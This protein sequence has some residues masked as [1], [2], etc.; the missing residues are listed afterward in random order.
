MTAADIKRREALEQIANNM[1]E[2]F[3]KSHPRP[4]DGIC[5]RCVEILT[6][7][8]PTNANPAALTS[9]ARCGKDHLDITWEKLKRPCGDL[10]HWAPCPET[11]E[12]IMMLIEEIHE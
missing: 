7:R 4:D 2:H 5:A 8:N 3:A 6:P 9:C 11:G 10:T 1:L 12:P